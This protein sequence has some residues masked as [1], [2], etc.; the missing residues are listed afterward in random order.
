MLVGDGAVAVPGCPRPLA[1]LQLVQDPISQ[2]RLDAVHQ[3]LSTV[4]LAVPI[5]NAAG[6]LGHGGSCSH[7][8]NR[9]CGAAIGLLATHTCGAL[10]P[11]GHPM[12][13]SWPAQSLPAQPLTCCAGL[14]QQQRCCSVVLFARGALGIMVPVLVAA[15]MYPPED[16][17]RRRAPVENAPFE[18]QLN[19]NGLPRWWWCGGWHPAH[20]EP[21]AARLSAAVETVERWAHV[22]MGWGLEAPQT[23]MLWLLYSAVIWGWAQAAA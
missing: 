12:L 17:R 20:F 11:S 5:T 23:P 15:L 8:S 18:P 16:L 13:L 9:Q 1:R 22:A 7:R 21:W 3:L 2:Q 4:Y 19:G 10:P 6:W 14:T